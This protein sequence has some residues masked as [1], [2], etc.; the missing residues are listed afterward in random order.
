M[1]QE[2]GQ[3]EKH[4]ISGRNK[5]GKDREVRNVWWMLGIVMGDYLPVLGLPRVAFY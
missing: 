1:F 4:I 5:M 2:R 3:K